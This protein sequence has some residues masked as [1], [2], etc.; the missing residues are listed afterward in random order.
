MQK[1]HDERLKV[2]YGTR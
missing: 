1:K 2:G